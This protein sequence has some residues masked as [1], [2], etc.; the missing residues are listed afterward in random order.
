MEPAPRSGRASRSDF[1]GGTYEGLFYVADVKA[2]GPRRTRLAC[3]S[4]RRRSADRVSIA[5]PGISAWSAMSGIPRA[6]TKRTSRRG[7]KP[8]GDRTPR[9]EGGEGE[10]VLDVQGASPRGGSVSGGAGVPARRC[11]AYPQSGGRAGDEHRDWRRRESGV[12]TCGGAARTR[13]SSILD[14]YEAERIAFARRL[15]ATTDQGFRLATARGGFARWVRT[16]VVPAVMPMVLK[17]E[18]MRRVFSGRCQQI[19]IR[20]RE[21]ALSAGRAGRVYAGD[22]LPWVESAPGRDDFESMTEL[23]WQVHVYGEATPEVADA[24]KEL[25]VPL[26]VFGWVPEAGAAGFR[27]NSVYAIRPDGCLGSGGSW[28]DGPG[29]VAPGILRAGA[30]SETQ[31]SSPGR[32]RRAYGAA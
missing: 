3:R 5:R 14:T 7:C 9:T 1:P 16:R 28:L 30:R 6:R 25:E 13:R 17:S 12:E 31:I 11:G 32:W 10:L 21:S 15:V 8:A 19:G 23:C 22:Q 2:E 4:G 27:R 18:W 26:H 20:Y 24:C 29:D